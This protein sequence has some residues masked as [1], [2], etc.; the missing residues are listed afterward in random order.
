LTALTILGEAVVIFRRADGTVAALEDA[1]PHRK[2]PLSMGSLQGDTV[3]CGYHGLTF[4]GSGR[5][6][7][8]PTQP[9]AIPSRARVR[10]YPM[11]DR[12]G[13]AWIWMGAADAA[14]PAALIDIP[15]YDNP[16]WGLTQRGHLAMACNYL[17]I[18]ENLLDPSHVAW[19]HVGSFAGSGT[20]DVALKTAVNDDGIIVY[21]WI[22]DRPAPPYYQPRL[23]FAGHCD[24][25]QH[26]EVRLPSVAINKSVFT[27]VG[28]GGSDD[29]L[30][31]EAF[32]NYSYNFMT[33][34]DAENTRYFWFQH[35]NGDPHDAAVSQAMFDGAV[36]AFNEDKDI[37]EAVQI[38]MAQAG[39]Q[40]INLGIDAGAM[41]FRRMVERRI[42][43]EHQD[44]DAAE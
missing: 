13:F 33:P 31:S 14:D 17:W 23:A 26:Y 39:R 32:V 7:A 3:V 16:N 9:D 11:L 43:A 18:M 41:R 36:T 28:T 42:A 20:D 24:R 35:R 27:P 6:V 29:D 22:P 30:P 15:N 25:K 37:L 4:D 12:Y 1:C 40:H 2:V 34:V 8:A 10:S 5:C 21:R 19:V 44:R 38:G